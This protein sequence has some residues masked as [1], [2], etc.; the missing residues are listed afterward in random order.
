MKE[1]VLKIEINEITSHPVVYYQGKRLNSGDMKFPALL[2]LKIDWN[3]NKEFVEVY[4]EYLDETLLSKKIE[5]GVE[6]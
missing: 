4:I 1:P 5:T 2:D 6:K 3:P